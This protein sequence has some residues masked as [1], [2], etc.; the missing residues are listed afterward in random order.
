MMSPSTAKDIVVPSFL[1][2]V[3]VWYVVALAA[4]VMTVAKID[5]MYLNLDIVGWVVETAKLR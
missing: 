2:K 3:K 1:A 4:S 5:S